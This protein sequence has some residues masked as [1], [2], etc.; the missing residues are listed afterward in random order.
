MTEKAKQGIRSR[1][2][3]KEDFINEILTSGSTKFESAKEQLEKANEAKIAEQEREVEET[4]FRKVLNNRLLHNSRVA[5]DARM[6]AVLNK[7]MTAPKKVRIYAE[8]YSETDVASPAT[9]IGRLTEEEI[10]EGIELE[11][12]VTDEL[13]EFIGADQNVHELL[14]K[15]MFNVPMT[16]GMYKIEI[17]EH[18][19]VSIAQIVPKADEMSAKNDDSI[20]SFVLQS[21]VSTI[22]EGDTYTFTAIKTVNPKDSSVT[23]LVTDYVKAY[24]DIE[25]F[26]PTQEE[27]EELRIFQVAEGQ[28]VASKMHEIATDLSRVTR[29]WGR[30]NII[31]AYDLVYHSPLKFKFGGKRVDRGWLDILVIGD[32]RTGKTETAERLQSHYELGEKFT[33]ESASVAGLTG[34]VDS[35]TGIGGS[36]KHIVRWGKFPLND[37]RLL[38]VD[39]MS[40]LSKDDIGKLSNIRSQGVVEISKIVGNTA[41]ARVRT[42]WISNPRNGNGGNSYMSDKQYGVQAIMDLIGASEDVARFD[43]AM[44]VG[45][46]DISSELVNDPTL[47]SLPDTPALFTQELCHRLILWAWSRNLDDGNYDDIIFGEGAEFYLLEK[48]QEVTSMYRYNQAMLIDPSS[49]KEKL[50]RVA[51]SA[52]ARVFSTDETMLKVLVTKEHIDFALAFIDELY[53]SNSLRYKTLA[54]KERDAKLVTNVQAIAMIKAV[55]FMDNMYKHKVSTMLDNAGGKL[56]TEASFMLATGSTDVEEVRANIATLEEVGVVEVQYGANSGRIRAS[57]R[58][59]SSVYP[60]YVTM[61]EEHGYDLTKE[62]LNFNKFAD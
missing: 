38:V 41:K 52:A 19:Y 26:N 28:S 15:K 46:D 60:H 16:G 30:S 55:A 17:L 36:G 43:F 51:I 5:F 14:L 20:L 11:I 40:G 58:W 61:Y 49:F 47:N 3:I 31:T 23:L 4:T 27:L 7:R 18:Y 56:I 33:A 2:Q 53:S 48:A 57:R 62:L 35:I 59:S 54:I 22:S 8:Y 32:S 25:G 9:M 12:S 34:G 39:E 45:Q 13:L 50:A 29:I 10:L 44:G 24:D 37:K 21:D 42:I 1:K 6:G